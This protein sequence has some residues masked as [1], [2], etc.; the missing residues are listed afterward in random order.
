MIQ[1]YLYC[2]THSKTCQEEQSSLFTG[3]LGV[4]LS[5]LLISGCSVVETGVILGTDSSRRIL[6][7]INTWKSWVKKNREVGNDLGKKYDKE[8]FSGRIFKKGECEKWDRGFVIETKW[9]LTD[10]ENKGGQR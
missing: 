5:I 9:C 7:E 3:V 1:I 8:L 4:V 2:N 6:G 10:D